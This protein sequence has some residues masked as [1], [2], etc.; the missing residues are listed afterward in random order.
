MKLPNEAVFTVE[1]FELTW[2]VYCS[3]VCGDAIVEEV[4]VGDGSRIPVWMLD[5]RVAKSLTFWA[6]AQLLAST[7]A[8]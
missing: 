5:E 3:V 8:A 1:A 2:K 4:A 6:N 7:E